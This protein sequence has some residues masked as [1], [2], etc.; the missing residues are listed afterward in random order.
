MCVN[1]LITFE[2][3]IKALGLPEEQEELLMVQAADLVRFKE[4][5]PGELQVI[6]PFSRVSIVADEQTS[7]GVCFFSEDDRGTFIR[8][9]DETRRLK[10]Y[11]GIKEFWFVYVTVAGGTFKD[12]ANKFINQN[13]I[14]EFCNRAFVLNYRTATVQPL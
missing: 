1:E 8:V 13:R 2:E 7:A 3:Q 10:K 9:M 12:R 6:D 4:S 5:F 11:K 14:K